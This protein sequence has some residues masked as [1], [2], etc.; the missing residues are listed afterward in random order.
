MGRRYSSATPASGRHGPPWAKMLDS[1]EGRY[2]IVPTASRQ[3]SRSTSGPPT[4]GL[5]RQRRETAEI[6]RRAA[7]LGLVAAAAEADLGAAPGSLRRT[8]P[9]RRCALSGDRLLHFGRFDDVV[10]DERRGIRGANIEV[11]LGALGMGGRR[12]GREGGQGDQGDVFHQARKMAPRA[13]LGQRPGF[14][15]APRA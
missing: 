7:V 4:V 6:V 11:V 9:R 1:S 13:G 12:Q 8:G 2:L 14:V 15:V 3:R 5:Q 10:D